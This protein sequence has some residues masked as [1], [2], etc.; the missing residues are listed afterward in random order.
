MTPAP[1]QRLVRGVVVAT[2]LIVVG[3]AIFVYGFR[4]VQWLESDAA[5]TVML[6]AQAIEAK[7]PIVDTWYYANGDIWFFYTHL[8][9]ILPVLVLGLGVPALFVTAVGTVVLELGVLAKAYSKLA[10]DRWV[11]LL[12]ALVSLAAWSNAHVAFN[13]IQ[14][15]Y[16]VITCLCVV[17]FVWAASLVER[18][19]V[20]PRTW[21]GLAA[22]MA[23]IGVQNPQRALVFMVAPLLVAVAWPWRGLARR[24]RIVLAA[25]LIAGWACAFV[26]YRLVLA[27][28]VTFSNPRGHGGF[29]LAD[30]DQ[31]ARNLEY[32][33][34]GMLMLCGAG[35]EPS[36]LAIP[37]AVI[38][39]GA[40][41]FV[42]REVFTSRALAPSRFVAV[43]IA[44]QLGATLVP[45]VVGNLLTDPASVR[46]LL[47]SLLAALGLG[48]ILA[49][50][51]LG[52]TG[53]VRRTIARAWLIAIP[54]TLAIAAADA[55]PPV[56]NQISWSVRYDVWP[57]SI[58]SGRVAQELAKRGLTRGYSNALTASLMT[59]Q[60]NGVAHVCPVWFSDYLVPQ[61][62]LT[63]TRCYGKD[64][65]PSRFFI[66]IDNTFENR[67]ALA[68]SLPP[69]S[70][71]F[72]V[73]PL[74]E[75]HVFE[76]A[77]VSLRWLD[78]PLPENDRRAFPL[79]IPA[80]HL[81]LKHG[82]VVASGDVM[83]ATGEEGAVL[84][85]PYVTFPRGRYTVRWYGTGIPSPGEIKF[86]VSADGRDKLAE[87]GVVASA[88]PTT[89][90]ELGVV[91]FKILGPRKAIELV[92]YSQN[93]GRVAVDEIV[94]ERR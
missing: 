43:A 15:S 57:D 84:Y 6:A 31:L 69:A 3:V 71:T 2:G 56:P 85:G 66:V 9:A 90:G 68:A 23:I 49:V 93:G 22:W 27:H 35:Y 73:G 74:Y 37:G 46:Y 33:G 52:E 40:L 39:L 32:L 7:L 20:G 65:L 41:A 86:Y 13:Y 77:E 64:T 78:L 36:P 60:S 88:L 81:Q 42:V 80:S 59:V 82:N 61:R 70:E 10:D 58:E 89:R 45:V 8:A 29:G 30:S 34:R 83:T 26:V 25:T 14:L 62:W 67:R 12:A 17:S 47:P 76:T 53:A 19:T 1:T 63:D 24:R 75:V 38:M 44:V 92:V 72:R 91:T 55:R 21:I 18:P 16:G 48:T 54:A 50:R 11:A 28:F 79:R 87:T 4:F 5:V 94:V 51:T